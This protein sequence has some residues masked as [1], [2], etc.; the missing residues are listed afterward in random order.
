MIW[1]RSWQFPATEAIF[2]DRPC[3]VQNRKV[4]ELVKDNSSITIAALMMGENGSMF[5]VV[6]ATTGAQ[7]AARRLS[8][9]RV[10]KQCALIGRDR[11]NAVR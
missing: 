3:Q 1:I 5:G 11:K 10:W 4:Q 6:V 7:H 9:T 2:K 8:P